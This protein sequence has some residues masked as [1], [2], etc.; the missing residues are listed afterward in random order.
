[1][2]T[3]DLHLT[4]CAMQMSGDSKNRMTKKERGGQ[5]ERGKKKKDR[6]TF[7]LISQSG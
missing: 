1:M 2:K 6:N 3:A 4:A 5:T 7:W